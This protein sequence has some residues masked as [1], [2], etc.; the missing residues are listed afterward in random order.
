MLH[1]VEH[2]WKLFVTLGLL[3]CILLSLCVRAPQREVESNELRRLVLAGAILYLVGGLASISH[4][5]ALA[6]GVYASG[7]LVCSVAV[8][9]S[10][11][12]RRDD[13][14]GGSDSDGGIGP[15]DDL[16]PPPDPDGL[17][18]FDWDEFERELAEY[19]ER[20]ET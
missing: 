7:I 18:E 8:W 15:S 13:G 10:R 11:G 20:V 17:P 2:N 6:A 3:S 5:P 1:T 9:L 19:S 4:R 16:R 12:V 14:D